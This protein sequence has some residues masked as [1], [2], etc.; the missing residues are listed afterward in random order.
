MWQGLES[1]EP[2]KACVQEIK[3]GNYGQ[4]H[5]LYWQTGMQKRQSLV[6]CMV[7]LCAAVLR[8]WLNTL[9]GTSIVR[10][11]GGEQHTMGPGL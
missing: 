9:C 10:F 11:T 2:P 1:I 7:P 5:G 6:L 4:T 8:R 3:Q